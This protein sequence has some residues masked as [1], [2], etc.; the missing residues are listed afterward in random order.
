MQEAYLIQEYLMLVLPLFL[1]LYFERNFRSIYPHRF[2]RLLCAVIC[3]A[4]IQVFADL[5]GVC[6]LAVMA[7]VSA[8]VM[9]VVCVAVL[10]SLI[11]L[12]KKN[13]RLQNI[14]PI[15]SV[16]VLL[17][18]EVAKV[19]LKSIS[20]YEYVE[21]AVLYTMT[22]S[23]LLL[24]I[25]HVSMIS[26]EYR[27]NAEEKARAAQEQNILLAQAKKDADAARQEALAANEAKGK[28]LAQ[29]SH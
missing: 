22:L 29:M 10:V 28:F 8:V 3:N 19:I 27:E 25:L 4:V 14:M 9:A 7:N 15:A 23:W 12:E 17:A 16:F 20:M 18:G 6:N 5:S 26:W 1:V 2:N 13:W 21:A 11:K 24:A